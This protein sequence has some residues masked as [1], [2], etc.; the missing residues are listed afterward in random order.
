MKH[1]FY[2]ILVCLLLSCSAYAAENISVGTIER[3]PFAFK[4]DTGEL[5]GFSVELWGHIAARLSLDYSWDEHQQFS[6]MIDDVVAGK[7]DLAIANISVTADREKLAD[8]SQPIIESGMVI[9]IKK[10]SNTSFIRLIWE[11]GILF[12]LM[13]AFLVLLVIA[14]IVWIFERGVS[15]ARHDYFRDD[16]FGGVWDAFWWAFIIM[17]M[18]GFENEVPHKKISRVI[19]VF[20]II[21][22]LFFI[23]TL[24]AKITTALTVAELQTGIEGYK[25]LAGKQVGVTNGS[26]HQKYLQSRGIKTVGYQKLDEMYSDLKNDRLD[27]IVADLPILAYYASSTGAG[28]MLL[29]GEPFNMENIAILFPENSRLQEAVNIALLELREEGVYADLHNKYFGQY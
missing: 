23:S 9:A 28:W 26:S 18:G 16:Y 11:S 6:N 17:T 3:P 4:S 19:A 13:G 25:D 14:H 22:S 15:D 29:A 2:L 10:G 27:A 8:F 20:W 12:F 24:T 7:N 21:V 1:Q 5:T